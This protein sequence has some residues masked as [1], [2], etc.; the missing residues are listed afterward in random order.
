MSPIFKKKKLNINVKPLMRQ[1]TQ[2]P[3]QKDDLIVIQNKDSSSKKSS[4]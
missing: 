1:S 4:S 2:G 3:S